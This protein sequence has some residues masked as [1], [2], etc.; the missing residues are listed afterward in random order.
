MAA[1]KKVYL[2]FLESAHV[3]YIGRFTKVI[4]IASILGLGF[5]VF[6]ALTNKDS[7]TIQATLGL[8]NWQ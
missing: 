4:L 1:V 2:V 3:Q 7:L 5:S 6:R 8:T